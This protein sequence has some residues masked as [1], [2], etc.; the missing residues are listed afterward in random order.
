MR[1][2]TIEL[3]QR[4]LADLDFER[5]VAVDHQGQIVAT[6]DGDRWTVGPRDDQRHLFQGATSI[7]N[8]PACG[9]KDCNHPFSDEDLGF[10]VAHGVW[11]SRVVS[12]PWVY[13]V[14]GNPYQE[15]PMMLRNVRATHLKV[16]VSQAYTGLGRAWVDDKMR[17]PDRDWLC[18]RLKED[19]RDHDIPEVRDYVLDRVFNRPNSPYRYWKEK[20]A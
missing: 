8:H 10:H 5:L 19:G 16:M 13:V 7:H 14:Q 18:Q 11:E 4:S 2:H 3:V 20:I 1:E 15:W 6:A 12:Y 9:L 17:G